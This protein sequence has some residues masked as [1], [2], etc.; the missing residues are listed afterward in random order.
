ME[1]AKFK[2]LG[3]ILLFLLIPVCNG[4]TQNNLDYYLKAAREN[5]PGI[6]ENLSQ[7]E[8]AALQEKIIKAEFRGPKVFLSGDIFYPPLL[9]NKND[10]KAV[11]YDAAITDGGLISAL[12]NVHQP[13]FNKEIVKTLNNQAKV[14]GELGADQA[15]TAQH[16]LEK[17]V[18]DQYIASYQSWSQIAFMKDLTHQMTQQ[19]VLIEALAGQGIYKKSDILLI[20]IEI[21]RQTSDI[22]NLQAIYNQNIYSLNEICG[23]TGNEDVILTAPQIQFR[24]DTIQSR[25]L[26]KFRLDS[27]QIKTNLD[28]ANLKYKPQ[29][30]LYGNTGI[31]A[32]EFPGIQRKFGVGAGLSMI[33]PI[34]DG[35]Q[36]N[37]LQEQANIDLRV[38][39]N[40]R[41][42]FLIQ[43]S[44]H[45][46]AIQSNLKLLEQK[47]KTIESQLNE[48]QKLIELYK[49][50]LRTGELKIIDFMNTIRLYAGVQQDLVTCES[51]KM[52]IINDN[53]FYN[54]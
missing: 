6:K 46:Q 19:K 25:F 8:K 22:N 45:Q 35:H 2:P 20:D 37:Y 31:N 43:K 51:S 14:T 49:S 24:A 50:E 21:L 12:V 33:I 42:N 53:N 10:P 17:E 41:Q 26:E 28:V 1:P 23:I 30:N 47:I 34:Y 7:V 4:L 54:W 3:L 18:I 11:G 9:P 52:L 29:F 15:R 5:N 44:N 13:V 40:Y 32:I 48:Y 39:N 27:L 38:N 36:F 16:L